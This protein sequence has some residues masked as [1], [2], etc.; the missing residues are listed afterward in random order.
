MR[1][2]G[3]LVASLLVLGSACGTEAPVPDK[4]TWVDDVQPILQANC[5]HCHGANANYG[6]WGTKRWDV[7][8]V[9]QQPYTDLGFMAGMDFTS[10]TTTAE[11]ILIKTYIADP[12]EGRMPPPPATPLSARDIETITKWLDDP[13]EGTHSPNHK[14]TI[15]WITKGKRYEVLDADGDQVLGQL[16]CGGTMFPVPRTGGLDFPAD[17]TAPCTATLFDGFDTATVT[18]K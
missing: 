18:L 14:P 12:G 13:V 2:R 5:F 10:P 1:T 3:W 16:D 4:P 7:F 6:K 11:K 15:A 17:A 8:D 9:S